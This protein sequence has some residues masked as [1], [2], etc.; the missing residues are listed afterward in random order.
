[1]VNMFYLEWMK[2]A[3]PA[4]DVQK[5]LVFGMDREASDVA[6]WQWNE[7]QRRQ[8]YVDRSD[9]YGGHIIY[10]KMY[11]ASTPNSVILEETPRA[12]PERCQHEYDCCAR[13]YSNGARIREGRFHKLVTVNIYQNV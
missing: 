13:W 1:M 10:W 8:R 2:E 11:P 5:Y 9:G 7:A 12:E 3:D 4:N 6:K